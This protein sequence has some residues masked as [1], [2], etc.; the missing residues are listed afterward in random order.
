MPPV[1]CQVVAQ[2]AGEHGPRAKVD[3]PGS[4]KAAHTGVN[5]WIPG[6]SFLPRADECGIGFG[7][8]G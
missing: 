6:A 2:E 3:V 1:L 5:Q 8:V 4:D 7:A